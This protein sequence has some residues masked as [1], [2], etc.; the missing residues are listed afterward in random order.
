[1]ANVFIHFEPIGPIDG[2][3]EIGKSDPPSY[4]IPGSPKSHIGGG[5][6]LMVMR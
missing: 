6:I 4:I 5:R 3:L 1:M 2:E